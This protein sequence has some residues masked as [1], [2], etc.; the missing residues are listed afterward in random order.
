MRK[1]FQS[2]SA[3]SACLWHGAA[4]SL[5][6]HTGLRRVGVRMGSVGQWVICEA[7]QARERKVRLA[8]ERMRQQQ[9]QLKARGPGPPA[10]GGEAPLALSAVNLLSMAIL[11]GRAER[12]LNGQNG[13]FQRGLS[14]SSRRTSTTPSSLLLGG[15]G[16]IHGVGPSFGPTTFRLE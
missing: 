4:P 3:L 1:F 2:R 14:P 11:G 6:S 13:D 7:A 10:R 9:Q 5:D 12:L 15:Q 8:E 16:N